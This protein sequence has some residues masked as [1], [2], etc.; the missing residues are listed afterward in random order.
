MSATTDLQKITMR[1]GKRNIMLV[2]FS[3][4]CGNRDAEFAKS[5]WLMSHF[6]LSR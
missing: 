4:I 2:N 3:A 5:L 1:V 6:S